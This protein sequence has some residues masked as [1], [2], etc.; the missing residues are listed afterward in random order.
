V[1]SRLDAENADDDIRVNFR[2]SLSFR[3]EEKGGGAAFTVPLLIGFRIDAFQ[4]KPEESAL[5][6]MSGNGER[7]RIGHLGES[8]RRYLGTLLS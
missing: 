2:M 5:M 8:G 6:R 1:G 7:G 4:N 3:M